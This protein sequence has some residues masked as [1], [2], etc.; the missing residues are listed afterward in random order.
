MD[1]RRLLVGAVPG[2][3]L[4]P[5]ARAATPPAG[6]S[7][8]LASLESEVGGR[9][10]VAALNTGTGAWLRH[11]AKERFAM[12][13]SFK[14][15]LAAAVLRA[16]DEG[17]LSGSQMIPYSTADLLDMRRGQRPGWR[18]APCRSSISAPRRWR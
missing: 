18:P 6:R 4:S 5:G 14:A 17:E 10:G 7:A 1:R 15:L 8:I 3:L 2:L 12:C 11:R 9:I 16:I 13:S